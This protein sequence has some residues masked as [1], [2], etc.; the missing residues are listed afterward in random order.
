MG[1]DDLRFNHWLRGVGGNLGLAGSWRKID[2]TSQ[3]T[4][5]DIP[6]SDLSLSES[7]HFGE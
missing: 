4:F 5:F 1:K 6:V 7:F 3:I 2:I